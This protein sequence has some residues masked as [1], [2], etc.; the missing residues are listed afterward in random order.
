M[1]PIKEE[2]TFDVFEK[3]D[4]RVGKVLA[5]EKVK[6]SKKLLKLLVEIGSETRTVVSGISQYYE[7]EALVGKNVVVIANLA[8]AK[9]MGIESKGMIL[10]ASD[11]QGKLVLADAP[12]MPSGSRVK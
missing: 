5:C 8:P 1:E 2:I 11:G 6:K 7:P 3:M 12:D 9:L 4:L 10:A